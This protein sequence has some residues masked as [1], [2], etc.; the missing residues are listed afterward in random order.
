M[1]ACMWPAWL[2]ALVASANFERLNLVGFK[3]C[4]RSRRPKWPLI[5]VVPLENTINHSASV[6]RYL[7]RP[8][9]FFCF[10]INLFFFFFL[11]IKVFF[12]VINKKIYKNI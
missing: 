8:Y 1:Y 10:V 5:L 9:Y 4:E 3:L 12:V 6:S 2:V 11:F 7:F